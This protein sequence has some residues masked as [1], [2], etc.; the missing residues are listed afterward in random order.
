MNGLTGCQYT[1]PYM[2]GAAIAITLL[3][4]E[5][6]SH[7][8]LNDIDSAVHAFWRS[9]V[10]EPESLVRLVHDTPLTLEERLRQKAIYRDTDASTL[11]LGF[12]TFYLNRTNRFRNHPWRRDRRQQAGRGISH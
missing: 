10:E 6:A 5:Y 3:Y 4:L 1:E 11:A 7:V 2:G 12:A 8:H 9:V